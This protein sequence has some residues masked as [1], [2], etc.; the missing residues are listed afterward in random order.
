MLVWCLVRWPQSNLRG[1]SIFLYPRQKGK[2]L[3]WLW[4]FWVNVVDRQHMYLFSF[5]KLPETTTKQQKNKVTQANDNNGQNV[6][7]TSVQ[8]YFPRIW[9]AEGKQFLNEWKGKKKKE[10]NCLA[11][12]RD[13]E[14]VRTAHGRGGWLQARS[15]R[16]G[17]INTRTDRALSLCPTLSL[18]LGCA[19]LSQLLMSLHVHSHP[20]LHAP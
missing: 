15:L 17:N 16:T 12:W 4:D 9:H 7:F 3:A 1:S 6:N 2:P 18:A 19:I 14:G 8:L 11:R 20:I 13:H 5:L 10:L